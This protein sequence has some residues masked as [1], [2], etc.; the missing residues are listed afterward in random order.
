MCLHTQAHIHIPMPIPWL[1]C[2]CM[3]LPAGRFIAACS[4]DPHRAC[5]HFHTPL[6]IWWIRLWWAINELKENEWKHTFGWMCSILVLKSLCNDNVISID[7]SSYYISSQSVPF[8]SRECMWVALHFTSLPV[9]KCPRLRFDLRNALHVVTL[10][11]W[12][13]NL[14]ESVIDISSQEW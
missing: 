12:G 1:I 8:L 14:L 11:E 9:S 7:Q 5:T 13:F 2:I 10:N 4:S 3:N 6:Y